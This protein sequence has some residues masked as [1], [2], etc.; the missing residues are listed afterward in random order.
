MLRDRVELRWGSA[1]WIP[2]GYFSEVTGT[3]FK[4]AIS[5][6][7]NLK[8]QQHGRGESAL[9]SGVEGLLTDGVDG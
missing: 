4:A 3:R 1:P 6:D 5:T 7:V 8:K 9:Q 2:K